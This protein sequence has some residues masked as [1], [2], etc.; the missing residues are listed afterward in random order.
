MTA[1]T[2][3]A[4]A[5]KLVD[6]EFGDFFIYPQHD[7]TIDRVWLEA[8]P[9]QLLDQILDDATLSTEAKFLACEV[10]FK[11]DVLFLRRHAPEQIAEVYA[12]ALSHDLTRMANSWGLLYDYQDEGPVGSAF[13]T[14]GQKAVR[15]LVKLLDDGSTH[16]KYLGSVEATVGN[17]YGYRVKDFAAYYLGRILGRPLKYYPTLAS[18]DEQINRLKKELGSIPS[19]QI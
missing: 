18:R 11:K 8:A 12:K 7:Q 10:L 13:L 3:A 17:A 6:R 9:P 1:I 5:Q 16:L 15:A 19:P 2:P 14:L 4:F